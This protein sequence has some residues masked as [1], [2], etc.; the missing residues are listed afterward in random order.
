MKK[1]LCLQVLFAVM[2]F[3]FISFAEAQNFTGP[4]GRLWHHAK[5]FPEKIYQDFLQKPKSISGTLDVV[6]RPSQHESAR[7]VT[8]EIK[9]EIVA[10]YYRGVPGGQGYVLPDEWMQK[11]QEYVLEI[12]WQDKSGKWHYW[13]N[14]EKLDS[15]LLARREYYPLATNSP[16]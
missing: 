6:L 3:A 10:F 12:R 9:D 5:T 8:A 16:F 15:P 13:W 2:F 14:K 11:Y 1:W 4:D 7:L